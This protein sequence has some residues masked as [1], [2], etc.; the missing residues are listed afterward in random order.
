MAA[1]ERE[2]KKSSRSNNPLKGTAHIAPDTDLTLP[3]DPYWALD[4]DS[5]TESLKDQTPPR[6]VAAPLQALWWAEKGDWERA[7]KIVMDDESKEGA[8]VHAYLHR[9][10]GD[11]ANARYWY[12]RAGQE[13]CESALEAEWADLVKDFLARG[14]P[15]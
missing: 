15:F 10:E 9:A 6:G 8:R 3:A 1:R 12:R 13:A 11:L 4:L 7:H 14:K 2:V 5:F